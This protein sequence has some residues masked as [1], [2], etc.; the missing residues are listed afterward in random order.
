MVTFNIFHNPESRC[1]WLLDDEAQAMWKL[2]IK[3]NMDYIAK[4][5][6]GCQGALSVGN[7]NLATHLCSTLFAMVQSHL[8]HCRIHLFDGAN[9]QVQP[10]QIEHCEWKNGGTDST[11]DMI[12]LGGTCQAITCSFYSLGN[13]MPLPMADCHNSRGKYILNG[14]QLNESQPDSWRSGVT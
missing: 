1:Q 9:A 7:I 8:F 2:T 10:V 5:T 4:R 3:R 14:R 6:E 13:E 12:I 11:T